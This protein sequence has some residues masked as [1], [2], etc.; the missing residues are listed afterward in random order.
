MTISCPTSTIKLPALLVAWLANNYPFFVRKK[1]DNANTTQVTTKYKLNQFLLE[2]AKLGKLEAM[3]PSKNIIFSQL[4]I[5][6]QTTISKPLSL[7]ATPVK[8]PSNFLN[9]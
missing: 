3:P 4:L 6:S 8:T 7:L 9:Y 1:M 2:A 5:R